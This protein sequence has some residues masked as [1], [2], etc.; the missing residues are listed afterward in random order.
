MAPAVHGSAAQCVLWL[1]TLLAIC[2]VLARLLPGV[3]SE[4][5][6]A[7]F[8]VR[9]GIL[10]IQD[11]RSENASIPTI[12]PAQFRD[13]RSSRQ[14]SFDGF[15][16][17]RTGR[18]TAFLP[19]VRPAPA[20]PTSWTVAHAS[21]NL[22]SLLGLP[23]QLAAPA[24]NDLPAILLSHRVWARDFHT[25]SRIAGRIVLLAHTTA[26]VAG[27]IPEGPW[28]LPGDPDAWLLEPSAQM[29][30]SSAAPGYLIAHLTPFG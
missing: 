10:L 14:R 27:V 17:Y 13:W 23:V 25:D 7:R 28:R 3:Q 19:G 11:A 1:A 5:E 9:P 15:A 16:F 12:T 21:P 20:R 4:I 22:F 29:A 6:S 8:Q 30:V 2:V 24:A 18:D 26:R